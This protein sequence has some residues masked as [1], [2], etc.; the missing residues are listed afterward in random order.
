MLVTEIMLGYSP[1]PLSAR[2]PPSHDPRRPPMKHLILAA[3]LSLT[4]GAAGAADP[5]AH[6]GHHA[7]AQDNRTVLQLSPDE[8]AMLLGEMHLFLDG[9]RKMTAALGQQD[10]AATA[11]AARPLGMKMAQTMPPALRAKLPLEFRQMGGPLHADFDQMALDAESLKDV[12][13]TLMQLSGTLQKCAGCH[14]MY[15]I[16]TSD[17]HDGN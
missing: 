6:D 5:H 4:L 7:P 8:R 11:A 16:R 14:A 10:M 1:S 9:V 13:Y 3:L 17:S 2:R 15:Q 12:S